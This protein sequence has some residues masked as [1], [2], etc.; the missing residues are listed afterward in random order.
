LN[1]DI[2]GLVCEVDIGMVVYSY[3]R[4]MMKKNDFGK[5]GREKVK[6]EKV[7]EKGNGA[8]ADEKML[9]CYQ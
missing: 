9:L 2:D 8:L 4:S 6:R 5:R 1:Y 3:G 7:V